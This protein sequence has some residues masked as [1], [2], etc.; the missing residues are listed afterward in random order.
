LITSLSYLSMAIVLLASSLP[1]GSSFTLSWRTR[2]FFDKATWNFETGNHKFMRDDQRRTPLFYAAIRSRLQRAE[3]E[4]T[5][6]D[7]GTGP[8]AL[9]AL[10]AARCG[11][12][13]VYAIEADPLSAAKAREAVSAAGFADVVEIIEG[14]STKVTLPEKVDVLISETVGSIASEEGLFATMA[15]AHARFV[16]RPTEQDSWIPHRCQTLGAPCSYAMH[17]GLGHPSFHFMSWKPAVDGPPRPECDDET[18]WLLASPRVLEDVRLTDPA[19]LLSAGTHQLTPSPVEF[20]V[21]AARLATAE[22]ELS[23]GLAAEGALAADA[24]AFA[25]IAARSLSG[26]AMWPRLEL[27]AE[28]VVDARGPGGEH[29]ESSW[30]LLLPLLGDRPVAIAP[31]AAV[32][33][34]LGVELSDTVEV[35]PCYSLDAV[36]TPPPDGE[37]AA[38]L[39]PPSFEL[40][41][42]LSAPLRRFRIRSELARVDAASEAAETSEE[43]AALRRRAWWR[44]RG[45]KRRPPVI[46]RIVAPGARDS[47]SD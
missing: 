38:P 10:E 45:K 12:K 43:R 25:R 44:H 31:T 1:L 22:A 41:H 36:V 2:P 32:T 33:V 16:A 46:R 35:P 5:L 28:V 18:L 21:E 3:G 6:L 26:V 15:D 24:K 27:D 47:E 39:A 30:P 11:A 4:L 9:L 37:D 34:S 19:A 40:L 17:H 20:T 23:T 14:I 42:R 29:A 8:F 7:L 13:K